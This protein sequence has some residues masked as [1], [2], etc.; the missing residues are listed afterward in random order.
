MVARLAAIGVALVTAAGPALACGPEPAWRG[1]AGGVTAALVAEPSI[2]VS[3]PFALAITL[4]G[5]GAPKLL[6]LDAGMPAHRHGMNYRPTL[7]AVGPGVWR[8][9][10]MMFHMPGVWEVRLEIEGGPAVRV[11]LTLR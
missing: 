2:R 1:T 7:S 8:A 9:E 3:E 5:D 10:G 6:R 4:C 11:K